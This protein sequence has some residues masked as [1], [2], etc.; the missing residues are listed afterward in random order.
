[1]HHDSPEFSLLALSIQLHLPEPR[2]LKEKR[3]IVKH[4]IHQLRKQFLCA[5]SETG[6]QDS[7]QR[8]TISAALIGSDARTLDKIGKQIAEWISEQHQCD[9]LDIQYF[10]L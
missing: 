8:C 3:G 2:S 5:A 10:A 1:M 4:L 6:Q 9:L 7:W